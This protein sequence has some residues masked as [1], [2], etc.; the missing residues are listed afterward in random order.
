MQIL[1]FYCEVNKGCGEKFLGGNIFGIGNM[2][3]I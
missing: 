1:D 2:L 3:E